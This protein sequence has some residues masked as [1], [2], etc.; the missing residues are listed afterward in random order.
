[1]TPDDERRLLAMG[2]TW[3]EIRVAQSITGP[4]MQSLG[5]DQ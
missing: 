2:V 4:F 5:Y 3:D 1:M